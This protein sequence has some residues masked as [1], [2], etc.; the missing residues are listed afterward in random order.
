[1][2]LF[3]KTKSEMALVLVPFLI[4]L[5]KQHDVDVKFIIWTMLEKIKV[6][7]KN[8]KN[9]PTC[10]TIFFEFMAPGTP[11]QNGGI[12]RSFATLYGKVCAMLNSAGFDETTIGKLWAEAVNCATANE[13]VTS[14]T[15]GELSSYEKFI[16]V[17]LA[18]S[19]KSE[20]SITSTKVWCGN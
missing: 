11:Q 5:K 10:L 13:N 17:L 15:R 8:A 7:M 1:M 6:S 4:Q 18:H 19:V 20:S 2:V 14:P 16:D 9:V 3:L 12:E